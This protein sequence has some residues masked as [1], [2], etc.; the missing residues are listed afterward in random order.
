MVGR[1]A[2]DET[3]RVFNVI[4]PECGAE[5]A[6]LLVETEIEVDSENDASAVDAAMELWPTSRKLVAAG[7][8]AS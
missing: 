3:M 8:A 1:V 4:G 6:G 2:H 5:I 7:T